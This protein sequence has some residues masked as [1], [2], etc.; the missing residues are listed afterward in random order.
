MAIFLKSG[1]NSLTNGATRLT[2]GGAIPPAVPFEMTGAANGA[3]SWFTDPRAVYYN[4]HTYFGYV[5]LDGDVYIRRYTHSTGIADTVFDLHPTLE[6][7]DH[8]NPSI[9]IR[10]SDKRL[11]VFYSAHGGPTIYMRISTNPEDVSAWG[12]ETSLDSQLGGAAYSY[13]WPIQLTGEASDP[14]YL[15]YR[16]PIDVNTTALRFSKST[17][18]GSTWAAQTLLFSATNRSSYYKIIQNG[19]D[20]I[21]FAI[22]DGSPVYD[23]DV[24]IYHFYYSGGNY[25]KTDGTL[26]V[27]GAPLAPADL[28]KV[29]DGAAGDTSWIWDVA[30]DG[31]GKP[32]VTFATFPSEIDHRYWYGRWTGAAWDT[33]EI[34]AGGTELYAGVYYS[35]GV[36]L[37]S[38]NPTIVYLSK[39]ISGQWEIYKYTTVDGGATWT[40]T[41]IT[42][43]SAA[44]NIRP[45]AVRNS[46]GDLRFLWLK[47]TYTTYTNYSMELWGSGS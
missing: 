5:T 19:T 7:D 45:V 10:D 39:Q 38:S 2:S 4:D 16:D 37:D 11:M 34:C 31:T 47:G 42:S 22:S 44:K 23:A 24:S 18:D 20:R 46:A 36:V 29:Y 12:A 1:A 9:L 21:D 3:W 8:N 25:Y 15:F 26:I 17:D 33:H 28:T 30:I 6:I 13:S 14:I 35:G 41:A 27:G 32:Y 43:G 40:A